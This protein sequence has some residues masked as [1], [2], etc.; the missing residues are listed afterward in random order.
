MREQPYLDCMHYVALWEV[1]AWIAN[2]VEPGKFRPLIDFEAEIQRYRTH[3]ERYKIDLECGNG[4]RADIHT[5]AQIDEMTRL[6]LADGVTFTLHSVDQQ[7]GRYPT[8]LQD[9]L[10]QKVYASLL[11]PDA[12][13]SV[14]LAAESY[15]ALHPKLNPSGPHANHAR[16]SRDDGSPDLA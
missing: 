4:A 2:H 7:I 8:A 16:K 1:E 13:V 10:R 5:D 9:Q 12:P 3:A 6:G 14:Q 11:L 15:R